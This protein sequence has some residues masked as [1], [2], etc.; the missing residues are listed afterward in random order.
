MVGASTLELR[1]ITWNET[2]ASVLDYIAHHEVVHP[3]KVLT[4][5]RRRLGASLLLL[6]TAWLYASVQCLADSCVPFQLACVYA[7]PG[8]RCF[9]LFH[10]LMPIEPLAFV[11]VALTPHITGSL[12]DLQ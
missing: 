8:R 10:G 1:H 4:R 2:P 11:H 12:S 5:F 7:G 6:P 9:G 3:T